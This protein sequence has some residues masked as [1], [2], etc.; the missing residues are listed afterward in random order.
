MCRE[1][2][3]SWHNIR[4]LISV[5]GSPEMQNFSFCA[6]QKNPSTFFAIKVHLQE[7]A[8]GMKSRRLS[9]CPS[10]TPQVLWGNSAVHNLESTSTELRHL[11]LSPFACSMWETYF[12]SKLNFFLF[13]YSNS[14]HQI[15]SIFFKDFI[16][17]RQ[18]QQRE[19]ESMSW[20]RGGRGRGRSRLPTE[21]GAQGGAGSQHP[22]SWLQ[23]RADTHSGGPPWCFWEALVW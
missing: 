3:S 16:W 12:S 19:R 6:N 17:E 2:S 1:T 21:Q 14:A 22:G 23:S 13:I 7:S 8:C 9:S 10:P 15:Y 20:R 5:E 18:R 4:D 11:H